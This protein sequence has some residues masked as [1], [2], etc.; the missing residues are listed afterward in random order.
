[1]RW[2]NVKWANSST[3]T[4]NVGEKPS[5]EIGSSNGGSLGESNAGGIAEKPG[6]SPE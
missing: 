4:E 3:Q 6:D 2:S 5:S 1:M